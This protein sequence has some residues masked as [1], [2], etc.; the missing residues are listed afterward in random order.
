[1]RGSGSRI[2]DADGRELIDYICSWGALLLG[3]AHP[4]VVES[5]REAVSRG[6]TF[7]MPTPWE[8]ELARRVVEWVPSVQKVRFVSSGTEATMSAVRLA[9]GA[10]GRSGILKFEGCY[11]GHVDSLLVKAGS[12]ALTFAIPGTPG[13]PPEHVAHTLVAPFNDSQAAEKI[14]R[15][16]GEKIACVIVEPVAGNM[17]VVPPAEGFLESLRRSTAESGCVLIFDEVITGFRLG[18]GGYQE[19]CGVTPDIT[20]MGKVLGGGLPLGAF[21]GRA[22]LMDMLAPDGP[23]YQAGT[24]SG[25]PLAVSAGAATLAELS[26]EGYYSRLESIA[27]RVERGLVEAAA[28]SRVRAVVNRVGSMITLFFTGESVTG[29][30]SACSADTKLY[31]SFFKEMRLRGVNLPPSQFEAWFVSSAHTE[32]DVDETLEAVRSSL[33]ALG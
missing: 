17:G 25:N 10:T 30:P 8:T 21:G 26:S 16:R 11:H 19:I 32:E 4:A 33:S 24:L 15:D 22:E 2:W 29:Y 7:G 1:V 20:T 14:L 27:S 12:G 9:R 5:V 31:A 6:S 28:S 13:V 18:R 3:H 23:V